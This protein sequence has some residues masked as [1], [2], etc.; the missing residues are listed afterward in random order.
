MGVQVAGGVLNIAAYNLAILAAPL[1]QH[2]AW[3]VFPEALGSAAGL[4]LTFLG[5]KHL[6]FRTRRPALTAA[7][8]TPAA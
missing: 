6:A 8:D 2:G 7:T 4:C 3:I 1:L 5:A